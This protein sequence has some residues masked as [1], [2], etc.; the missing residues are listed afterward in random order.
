LARR[1][2][3]AETLPD[4]AEAWEAISAARAETFALNLDRGL[5]VLNSWFGLQELAGKKTS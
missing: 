1:L 4:W 5:L 3:T 2:L